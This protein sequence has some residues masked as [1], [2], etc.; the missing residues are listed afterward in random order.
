VESSNS[1]SRTLSVR[2]DKLK[3]QYH[4]ELIPLTQKREALLREI[5]ELK[6][7]RDVFLEETTVLNA[8]NEELAQLSAQYSRKIDTVQRMEIVPETPPKSFD[9]R[10]PSEDRLRHQPSFNNSQ[11]L[12]PAQSPMQSQLNVSVTTADEQLDRKAI[13]VPRTKIDL[14]TP[15]K[16]KFI[17]WP[18]STS[19][20][21]PSSYSD[22]R[23]KQEHNFQ[24]LSV[25]RFARCDHCGDKMWG[26]QL[27]CTAC[28]V[29]V[30]V[31]CINH[32]HAPCTQQGITRD[33]P[34]AVPLRTF[35]YPLAYMGPDQFSAPSMF[36]RD[37]V[38]QVHADSRGSGRLVP[39]IVE[40]CIDAVE[41]I[42][43]KFCNMVFHMLKFFVS[44]T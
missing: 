1:L 37:L 6:A 4:H 28:N 18:G 27:R 43:K 7:A 12:L 34:P 22:I 17:K 40:K 29:S 30:H 5:T 19:K 41:I 8:R 15:S 26:S 9:L 11:Q 3:N 32:V 13:S 36:G 2:L 14:P 31:R 21:L 39:V 20:E 44:S 10:R 33:D 25:L 23:S 42:G 24:Q 16:G 35:L 38:E